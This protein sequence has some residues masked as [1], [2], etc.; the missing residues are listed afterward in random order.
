M[1]SSTRWILYSLFRVGLFAAALAALL[2]IGLELWVSAILATI[3]A[4]CI[5]YVFFREPRDA[6][7]RDIYERRKS[8]AGDIEGDLENLS[9][10]RAALKNDRSGQA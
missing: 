4:F 2:L 8:D 7:A 6:I 1:K 10:D 3:V 9:L 5:S